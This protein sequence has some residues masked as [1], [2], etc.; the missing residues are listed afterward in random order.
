MKHIEWSLIKIRKYKTEGLC[1]YFLI[2]PC[3]IGFLKS[4]NS[5]VIIGIFCKYIDDYQKKEQ[6]A[7]GRLVEKL[8]RAPSGWISQGDA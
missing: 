8:I 5:G 2:V 6:Y 1:C 7:Q 4:V 3:S